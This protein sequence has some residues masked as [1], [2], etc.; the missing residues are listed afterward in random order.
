MSLPQRFFLGM[1]LLSLF[2]M[3]MYLM[4]DDIDQYRMVAW[5]ILIQ[6]GFIGMIVSRDRK[7]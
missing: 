6:I 4:P 5:A 1:I 7:P 3:L 2:S